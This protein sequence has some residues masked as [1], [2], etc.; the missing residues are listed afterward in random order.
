MQRTILDTSSLIALALAQ[1]DNETPKHDSHAFRRA[2]GGIDEAIEALVLY[3]EVLFDG[4]SLR[5]NFARL[6]Q[7]L[8]LSKLGKRLGEDDS[9]L[10]RKVY[11]SVLRDYVPRIQD[12]GPG[13]Q[14]LF[15][16]HTEAWMAAELGVESYYPSAEWRDIESELTDEAAAVAKSLRE[17]FGPHV[18]YSGAACA[19]LL[20]TLYYDCLQQFASANLV[21]HPLKEHVA[22]QLGK[23]GTLP[24]NQIWGDGVGANLLDI[25]DINVRKAF[26]ERKERWLGRPDLTYEVPMLT[27]FVLNKCKSWQDLFQVVEELRNSKRASLFRESV[28]RLLDAAEQRRNEEVEEVLSQL[29]Q[30]AD[31]WS[32]DVRAKSVSKKVTVSVPLINI[33]T[34]LEIPDVK[35]SRTTGEK[36]LVFIH[37]ILA[38]S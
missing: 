37:S 5:R 11:A 15:R 30:A 32:K 33:N 16:M 8:D 22:T 20:R 13:S 26:Y 38:E 31:E 29:N 9:T 1:R 10:E 36:L 19:L 12:P 21:L 35:F 25:F 6:P 4:P 23:Q 17:R 14:H 2:H 7:L 28:R 34:E 18:P 27:A 3:D 24:R